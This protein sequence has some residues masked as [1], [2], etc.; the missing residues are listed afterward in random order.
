MFEGGNIGMCKARKLDMQSLSG[1]GGGG[2]ERQWGW[3]RARAGEGR[4]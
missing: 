4:I 1:V 3:R 2:G